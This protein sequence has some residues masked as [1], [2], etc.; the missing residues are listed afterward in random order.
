MIS[1]IKEVIQCPDCG[2]SNIVY[3]ELRT[4]VICRDCGLV[5]EPL[6]PA[7]EAK[8]E[9]IQGM[10]AKGKNAP[11]KTP[12]PTAKKTVKRK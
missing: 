10:S 11:A 3:S 7:E 5:Y 6:S 8:F 4:Q 9:K 2:S 1:D 12:K